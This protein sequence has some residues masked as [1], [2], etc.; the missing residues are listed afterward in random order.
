MWRVHREAG[1]P[2]PTLSEDSVIDYM[3]M[4]A[5]AIKVRKE[6]DEAEKKR[7]RDEWKKDIKHLKNV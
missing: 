6:D 4:E 3:V 7:K 1:R 5:V 2:W